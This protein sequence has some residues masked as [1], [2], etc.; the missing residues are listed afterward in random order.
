MQSQPRSI[1]G[2]RQ[3]MAP[4]QRFPGTICPGTHLGTAH[5]TPR[6]TLDGNLDVL[7]P[8]LVQRG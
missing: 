6:N 3:D 5:R 7:L 8:P 4:L 2:S 1:R